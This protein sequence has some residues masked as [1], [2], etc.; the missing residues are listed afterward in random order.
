MHSFRIHPHLHNGIAPAYRFFFQATL[1]TLPFLPPKYNNYIFYTT[2]ALALFFYFVIEKAPRLVPDK[3]YWPILVLFFLQLIGMVYTEDLKFGWRN[4]ETMGP[5]L[6]VP[7]LITITP[8]LVTKEFVN[9][10]CWALVCGV[11]VTCVACVI[12][13][14]H[15]VYIRGEEFNLSAFSHSNFSGVLHPAYLGFYIVFC[16]FFLMFRMIVRKTRSFVLI[17]ISS[18]LLIF[19]VFLNARA[20]IGAFVIT[21]VILAFLH[22]T[23]KGKM[24]TVAGLALFLILLFLFPPTQR[25]FID[26]PRKVFEMSGKIDSQDQETWA[27]SFRIQIY[28]CATDLIMHRPLFGVGTGD[29][30]ISMQNCYSQNKYAWLTSR[31]YNAHSEYLQETIRHGL[32]GLAVLIAVFFLPLFKALAGR[33][34]LYS[35][36]L[37]IMLICAIPETIFALHKGA[38][39]FA[40]FYCLLGKKIRP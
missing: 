37:I 30:N 27:M 2:F 10:L 3:N 29:D 16:L 20:S 17:L 8:L 26:A 36:F 39:F 32:I 13:S 5:F 14:A 21:S 38:F 12:I 15:N 25:R 23:R 40:L 22:L 6:T 31:H 24:L 33:D 19:L 28:S 1:F 35:A 9:R 4:I 34:F 11:F 7:V 18:A